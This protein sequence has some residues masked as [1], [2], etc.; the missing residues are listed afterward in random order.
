VISTYVTSHQRF[1]GAGKPVWVTETGISPDPINSGGDG[2]G[3]ASMA[4]S[5]WWKGYDVRLGAALS[6]RSRSTAGL[7]RRDFAKGIVLMLEP[8]AA[9]A[10]VTL[11]SPYLTIDGTVVTQVSLTAKQGAVLVAM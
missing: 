2:L 11:P 9:N 8:G 5:T 6:T 1:E 4:P 3:D 10:T 7:F